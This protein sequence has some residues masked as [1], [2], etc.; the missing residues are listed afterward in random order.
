V[1]GEAVDVL[2]VG[3][4]VVLVLPVVAGVATR[5]ARLVG[6]D[7]AAEVVGGM[8]LAKLLPGGGAN[9]FPGPVH[10]LH[11]LVTGLVVTGQTGLRHLRSTIE[12]PL[13]L[14]ELAVVRRTLRL[15]T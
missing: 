5:A 10:A 4:V 11:D 12:W 9:G 1:T 13:K 14:L 7:G 6:K 2:F 15:A 8:L 3:E